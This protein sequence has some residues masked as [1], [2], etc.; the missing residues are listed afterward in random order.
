MTGKWLVDKLKNQ[1]NIDA[2]KLPFSTLSNHSHYAVF[3]TSTL[4]ISTEPAVDLF[5]REGKKMNRF[6]SLSKN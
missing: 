1:K 4:R 2:L 3:S 6:N 5:E